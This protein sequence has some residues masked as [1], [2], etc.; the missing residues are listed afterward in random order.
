MLPSEK[1]DMAFMLYEIQITIIRK[2]VNVLRSKSYN[3]DQELEF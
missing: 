1:L 2:A 3:P